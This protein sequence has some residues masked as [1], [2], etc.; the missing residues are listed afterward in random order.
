VRDITV[1]WYLGRAAVAVLLVAA[2]CTG[3][4][5]TEP[6]DAA[7]S[8]AAPTET[9]TTSPAEPTPTA[10][11]PAEP[12]DVA[13]GGASLEPGVYT[14]SGFE[15]RV[16][17]EVPGGWEG[18]HTHDDFF[19]VW[20]EE[21]AFVGFMR[22][23]ELVTDEGPVPFGDLDPEAAVD[24]IA[25]RDGVDATEPLATIVGGAAGFAVDVSAT[26]EDVAMF[27]IE[28]EEDA[29]P[30]PAGWWLRYRAVDVGG[31]TVIVAIGIDG[32]SDQGLLRRA[33]AVIHTI[34][35]SGTARPVPMPED[36]PGLEPGAYTNPDFLPGVSF[37]VG[38]GW[39]AGHL[40]D[41]FFDVQRE[42]ML[43]GF[44]DP[45]FFVR[46]G[47]SRVPAGRLDAERAA[48]LLA[49]SMGLDPSTV[50]ADP[51]TGWFRVEGESAVT[52]EAFGADDGAFGMTAGDWYRFVVLEMDDHVVLELVS[53][54]GGLDED[55][56]DHADEVLETARWG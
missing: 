25:G 49:G 14:W 2:A 9:P 53:I 11:L 37:D 35:W 46:F 7:S 13:G 6:T 55:L 45:G 42:G 44:A 29:V 30:V 36:H 19:D 31:A 47:G 43:V 5:A 4:A 56:L 27:A 17:F 33:D 50:Q 48:V 54:P 15:P 51:S 28:G 22:P 18:G 12:V 23:A 10:T 39:D 40:V 1:P 38:E 52:S 34:E 32:P 3:D 24:A 20:L 41:E 8:S 16:T 21:G 26:G